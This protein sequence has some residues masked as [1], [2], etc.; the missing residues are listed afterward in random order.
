ME[1]LADVCGRGD[2]I[3]HLL[4]GQD[5]V[6]A[7]SGR[8]L[9]PRHQMQRIVNEAVEL[10]LEHAKSAATLCISERRSEE[11]G[12]GHCSKEEL[13]SESL[14]VSGYLDERV[15]AATSI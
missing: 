7:K 13:G 9:Q 12:T 2:E 15:S 6:L 14:D 8:F 10:E 11:G 3:K 5:A 1:R 4:S